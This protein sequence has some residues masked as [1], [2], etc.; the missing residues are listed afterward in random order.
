VAHHQP[1]PIV[2]LR[3]VRVAGS[4]AMTRPRFFAAMSLIAAMACG[5][6]AQQPPP[7]LRGSWAASAG[8]A[9]TFQGTWTAELSAS[10]P[11]GAQGSWTLLNRSNQITARGTWSAVKTA[12]TWSGTW[13][14][15]VAG[16]NRLLSGSWRTTIAASDVRSLGELLQHTLEEQVSGTWASGRLLGSWSLRAMK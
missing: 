8:R 1:R 11:D 7:M 9:Q 14:A 2:L 12:R 6:A 13:Q 16:N 10:N 15:R 4:P 5:A 3:I